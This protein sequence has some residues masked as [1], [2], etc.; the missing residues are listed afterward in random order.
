MGGKVNVTIRKIRERHHVCLQQGRN[1]ILEIIA[2]LAC[3][4]GRNTRG[5]SPGD[6]A[7]VDFKVLEEFQ[8]DMEEI[9]HNAEHWII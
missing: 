4:V 1:E 7:L 8:T 3:L 6:V 5:G 2:E 9:R